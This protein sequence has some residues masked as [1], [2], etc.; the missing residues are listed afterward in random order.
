[1]H[2]RSPR[3]GPVLLLGSVLLLSGC[4]VSLGGEDGPSIQVYSARSYGAEQA[5]ERFTEE[6]GIEVE[7]LNGSD[8]ELRERLEVE[9]ADSEADVF[10]TVD[11][12]NLSLAAEQDLLQPVRS[13]ELES[14][15][16]ASLR[17]PEGRWFGLSERARV[18]IYNTDEVQP[19]ELSTYAALGDAR[20]KDRICF[21]TSTSAYTQSLVASFIAHDGPEQ[22]RA[23]VEGWVAND[24]QI[25]ANDPEIVRTVAAGGC[26]VGITN[27]YYVGREL[28]KDPDLPIGVFFPDQTTTGTH[29]NISG[30]GVTRSADDVASATTFLEWLATDGQSLFVDGNFEY[31]VNRSVEPTEV[32]VGFGEFRRDELNV[33]ELGRHNAEAVQL[34]TDAGYR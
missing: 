10:M 27:H 20:W 5:Y 6:T 32:L 29:V 19:A 15:V 12:A 22:A 17:D 34:L 31:P 18:V 8:A 16:P 30:A 4:G 13:A 1:V 24:P 9:G 23:A 11:V 26:D 3:P 7:F 28:A 2:S 14:A 25:L 33:G 21:R